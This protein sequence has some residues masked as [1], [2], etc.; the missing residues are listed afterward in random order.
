MFDPMFLIIEEDTVRFYL[1]VS[2]TAVIPGT[3]LLFSGHQGS[4]P[5]REEPSHV[6]V[7]RLL[8]KT[9]QAEYLP[10]RPI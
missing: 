7:H 8:W 9:S 10:R 6:R 5:V 3:A 4:D 1:E 2:V